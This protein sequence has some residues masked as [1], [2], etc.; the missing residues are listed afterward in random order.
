MNPSKT[1]R[2]QF[3]QTLG[4]S[5]LISTDLSTKAS[6]SPLILPKK[7]FSANDKIRIASFGMGII[8]FENMGVIARMPEAEFVAAADCYDGRL[9]RTKEV[10]GKEVETTRS[11]QKLLERKDI[12]AVIINTPDHWHAQMAIEAMQ[13]GKAVYIEKPIIQKIEDGHRI[14]AAQ[15]QTGQVAIVGSKQFRSPLFQKVKTMIRSGAIGRLNTVE[16]TVSR[17][18]AMGAWQYTI[19]SDASEKTIDWKAFLGTA[20]DRA[21]DADRFFRW[22]K[23][24]DYGTGVSGDMFVH[25]LS[26]LH[27]ILDSKGPTQISAT[28]GVRYWNDGREAPDILMALLDYPAT[29]THPDFTLILKA[30]FADGSGGGPSYTFIG[31]EGVMELQ[32]GKLSVRNNRRSEASEEA[33]IEGYNSV[34]TFAQDQREEFVKEFRQYKRKIPQIDRYDFGGEQVFQSPDDYDAGIDHFSRFFNAMR[35]NDTIIQNPTYGLRAAAP[36][37]IPNYCYLEKKV[38]QWDPSNMKV[39]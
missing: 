1:S 3:I 28:G 37:I 24:W 17:N 21:F 4:A 36:S 34:R 29:S 16:A 32:G 20:P 27:F 18:N 5:T 31:S 19:P 23:Y 15:K 13:A 26:G 35:G 22:R 2:R 39:V 9:A 7:T 12:D 38:Y 33:L 8:A 11:Y 10:F 25:R 30:N 6:S 14:I